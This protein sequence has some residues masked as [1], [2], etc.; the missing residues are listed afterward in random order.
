M[1]IRLLTTTRCHNKAA[2]VTKNACK[3]ICLD[4]QLRLSRRIDNY[5]DYTG[6]W[7][8]KLHTYPTSLLTAIREF[9]TF[10]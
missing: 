6:G 8:N 7:C 10:P 9:L 1:Y 3:S 5:A 2:V 4:V